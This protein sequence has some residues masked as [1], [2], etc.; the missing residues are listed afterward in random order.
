MEAERQ[1]E[2]FKQLALDF[3]TSMVKTGAWPCCLNCDYWAKGQCDRY[4][5]VPPP[6]VIVVGCLAFAHDIPF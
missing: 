3:Q 5:A 6:D 4:K 1:K 2:Q